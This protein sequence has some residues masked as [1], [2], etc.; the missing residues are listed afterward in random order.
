MWTLC[1]MVGRIKGW[2]MMVAIIA[3]TLTCS[4]PTFAQV[5]TSIGT[6]SNQSSPGTI[7]IQSQTSATQTGGGNCSIDRITHVENWINGRVFECSEEPNGVGNCWDES[8]DQSAVTNAMDDGCGSWLGE[9]THWFKDP[10]QSQTNLAGSSA[11]LNAGTC[12]DPCDYWDYSESACRSNEPTCN[13][14][15]GSCFTPPT[16]III[17]TGKNAKYDLTS[18]A[19][20]VM[21]DIDGDGQLEQV[22]WTPPNSPIAFLALDRNNDGQITSGK[23]LFGNFT[24]PGSPNGFDALQKLTMESNGG[25]QRH[26]V[27]TDDPIFERLLLWTDTNHNGLSE[28]SE[29]RPAAD[30]ISDIGLGYQLRRQ[31]DKH[32]NQFRYRGW[33]HIR[34]KPGRDKVDSAKNN[35]ERT[36]HIWDVY[37]VKMF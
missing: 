24:V 7:R 22:S 37:L 10:G 13:W 34:T 15:S 19:E 1:T 26:S 28:G 9:A 23:E 32:G 35:N 33:I 21:F 20:G 27:S 29:L 18:A 31:A 30:L 11:N 14:E 2:L 16:P 36:R 25:I 4:S 8:E 12:S 17:A 5:C 6:S 3:G